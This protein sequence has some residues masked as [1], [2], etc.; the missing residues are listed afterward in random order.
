MS[1]RSRRLVLGYV[2]LVLILAAA[3]AHN[4]GLYREHWRLLQ[5]KQERQVSLSELRADAAH[6]TGPL[7]VREWAY[8]R[9]MVSTPEGHLDAQPVIATPAPQTA[10]RNGGLEIRTLWR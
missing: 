7:A 1:R 6:I 9:G 10:V 3:G 5:V 4:Q 8:E 2:C